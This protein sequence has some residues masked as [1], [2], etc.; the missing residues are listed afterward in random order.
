M[1]GAAR[2]AVAALLTIVFESRCLIGMHAAPVVWS[3]QFSGVAMELARTR[4]EL[5]HRTQ[6]ANSVLLDAADLIVGTDNLQLVGQAR[7]VGV[8]VDR[9][10]AGKPKE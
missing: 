8:P 3:A 9:M 2:K 7:R 5:E 4:S 10:Q 6:I 1:E